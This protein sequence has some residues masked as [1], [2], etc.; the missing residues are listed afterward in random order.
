MS[1]E[2]VEVVRGFFESIGRA[3]E[4][5]LGLMQRLAN[6][7]VEDPKMVQVPTATG[8]KKRSRNAGPATTR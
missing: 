7:Y 3:G 6:V 4:T 8:G 2:N 1:Q 5:P